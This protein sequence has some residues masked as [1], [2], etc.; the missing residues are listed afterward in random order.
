MDADRFIYHLVQA[1]SNRILLILDGHATHTKNV[2]VI[3]L[4]RENGIT[5]LVLPPHCTHRLQPLD[6][7]FMKPLSTYYNQ[8]IEV[9]LRSNPG[10][11]VTTFQITQLFAEAYSKAANQL[12]A[13]NGFKKTGIYPTN[14]YIFDD[15]EFAASIPTE[16]EGKEHLN[17]SSRE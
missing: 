2:D 3:D 13:I 1:K 10:R 15:S 11:V 16:R 6:V 8:A 4:A 17:P 5:I 7:T 12:T 9:W 14:R